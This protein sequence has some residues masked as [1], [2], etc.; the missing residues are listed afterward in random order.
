[1]TDRP[2]PGARL[3]FRW[4]KWDGSP[5]WEHECVYLGSDRWGDWVGQW[6]GARS[7]RPGRDVRAEGPNVTLVPPSGEYAATFN[8]SHP[9][10]WIYIDVAW[11]VGWRTDPDSGAGAPTGIDM[12]LDVVKA[13]DERGIFIDDRDEWDEHRVA[14]G[15]P[16]EVVARLEQV[17][18]DLEREVTASIAP[19]DDQTCAGWLAR[20]AE[21]AP[22][23]HSNGD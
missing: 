20:L 15:Y 5:H 12:D 7:V 21:F 9:R 10:V 23:L 6:P 2:A 4:R 14:Y 8:L 16:P 22:G 17:A 18:L 1:V 11:D 19:F 13:L 3:L